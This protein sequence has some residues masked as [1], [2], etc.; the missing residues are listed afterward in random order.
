M[1]ES[2]RHL[3]SRERRIF[4]SGKPQSKSG[5]SPPPLPKHTVGSMAP[6]VLMLLH[7]AG[8]FWVFLGEGLH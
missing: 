4:H 7:A 3:P 5:P 1:T 2:C 6:V 8:G